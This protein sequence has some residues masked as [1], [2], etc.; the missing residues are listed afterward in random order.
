M[1]GDRSFGEDP[2]LVARLGT[3]LIQGLQQGGVAACAKHFPGHGDTELDSHLDLPAVDH[4]RSRLDEVELGP[5]RA[6][7]AAGVASVM[8]SHILVREIDDALPATL[9]PRVIAGL[10]REELGY[11]GVVVTDDLEM[12]ALAKHWPPAADRRARGPGRLRPPGLLQEP[13]RAGRGDRGA[14]AGL[15]VGRGALQG[16]GG[17]RGAA[18]GRSRSASWPATGSRPEAGAAGGGKRAHRALAEAIA[19]RSGIP[20]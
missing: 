10:L 20:A 14:R 3:A 13:R 12:Q 5:F 11:S 4:S 16:A 15:R 6:A 18:C 9:S 17:V 7:I 8:T 19:V 2:E 1:I